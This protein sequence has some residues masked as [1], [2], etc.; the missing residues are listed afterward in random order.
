MYLLD[1]EQMG[2][3]IKDREKVKYATLCKKMKSFCVFSQR[4]VSLWGKSPFFR[5]SIF[6]KVVHTAL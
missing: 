2:D 5:V 1:A 3:L 4:V 6:R